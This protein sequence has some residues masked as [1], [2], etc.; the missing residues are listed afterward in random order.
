MV[1]VRKIHT[2]KRETEKRKHRDDEHEEGNGERDKRMFE[3]YVG[4]RASNFPLETLLNYGKKTATCR[5]PIRLSLS[6]CLMGIK[7]RKKKISL[8]LRL[9]TQN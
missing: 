2:N 7:S 4:V 6:K 3:K 9:K 1:H 8:P 5:K